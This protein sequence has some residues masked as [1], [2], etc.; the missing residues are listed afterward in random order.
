[1]TIAHASSIGTA[2]SKAANQT[3][4]QLTTNANCFAGDAIVINVGVDNQ[5]TTDGD[6]GAI[7][8]VA[9][10]EGND[11]EKGHEHTNGQGTAQ[12]GITDGV[13][14]C[15][16]K[17]DLPSGS[18]ITVS[19]SNNTSR[20][21]SA[22]SADRF[23]VAA[24]YKLAKVGV[25]QL[26]ND[27]ANPGSLNVTTENAAHLRYRGIAGETSATGALTPT[28]GWTA[29]AGAQTSGGSSDTNVGVRGEFLIYTGT[30]A[31]SA[32]TLGPADHASVYVAFKEQLVHK[33]GGSAAD[34]VA[35][36]G[37]ITTG[38]SIAG[39][40]TDTVTAQAGITT[41]QPIS[42]AATE[43]ASATGSL[44]TGQAVSGTASDTV[45]ATGELTN[46]QPIAGSAAD[47]IAAGAGLD[48]AI[49]MQGSAQSAAITSAQ[50]TALTRLA[51]Q[52][53]DAV[54][55]EADLSSAIP[56]SGVSSVIAAA[57]GNLTALIRMTGASVMAALA[58]AG[59]STETLLNASAENITSA[60]GEL[61]TEAQLAGAAANTVAAQAAVSVAIKLAGQ[62]VLNALTQG[63]LDSGVKLHGAASAEAVAESDL[64]T[65][66]HFAGSG[67][68]V[69]SG[70]GILTTMTPLQGV[71]ASVNLATGE[72]TLQWDVVALQG[73]ANAETI[74]GAV[75][76]AKINLEAHA[77]M[78]ALSIAAL[79]PI[80]GYLVG[81]L[82][83]SPAL[84]A[85]VG[86]NRG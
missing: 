26:S 27:A 28:S 56:L 11:W 9:D 33:L 68:S 23:T 18:L 1:M 21:A 5:Q 32:P 42:G 76:T 19:F 16:L 59:I 63:Q 60:T 13:W 2:S 6:E 79:K 80:V 48:S 75:L 25:N 15:N 61:S 36:S 51:G 84:L 52:A 39:S 47:T 55:A 35:A 74:A 38:Q 78:A 67:M 81:T 70:N 12:T 14:F 54:A 85:Y 40:A 66:I 3:S 50:L 49:L 30:N 34:T 37:T 86:L 22:A 31:A 17:N 57:N 82:D 65:Q 29:I 7:A 58:Q 45:S 62:S 53:A 41:T 69:V 77:V 73:L 10:S 20:D 46:S 83:T 8:G 44:S 72:L 71:A 4:L 64:T 24:G 43:Q